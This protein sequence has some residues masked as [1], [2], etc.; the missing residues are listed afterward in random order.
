[1]KLQIVPT[2]SQLLAIYQLPHGP[3]RFE[4]Y[5]AATVDEAQSSQQV[6]LPPLIAA[7]PMADAQTTTKLKQWLALAAEDVAAAWLPEIEAELSPQQHL[8]IGLSLLDDASGS[9]TNRYLNDYELRFGQQISGWLTVPLWSS[10]SPSLKLLRLTLR[11]AI[12]RSVWQQQHGPAVTLR[13]MLQQEGYA[14]AFA[15]A[16]FSLNNVTI[17]H[18]RKMLAPHLSSDSLN[19]KALIFTCLYGD[20]AANEVG[21][22]T[23]GLPPNAG[24]AVALAN[25]IASQSR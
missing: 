13:Q 22:P 9:W 18:S 15:D 20:A 23:L 12:A 8:Q 3:Q 1:M 10:D 7:N 14:L 4:A 17:D 21:Y 2:L 24:F 16:S 19:S 6:R 11:S 5:L 25:A